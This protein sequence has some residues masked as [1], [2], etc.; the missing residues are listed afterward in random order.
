MTARDPKFLR[1]DHEA[2]MEFDRGEVQVEAT[3]RFAD[4]SQWDGAELVTA[5]L[6][7]VAWEWEG[8]GAPASASSR[9]SA[10]TP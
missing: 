10:T 8:I 4:D 2:E 1:Y 9:S 5:R 3:G 7:L 6:T